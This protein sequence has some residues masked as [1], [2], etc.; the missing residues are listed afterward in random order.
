[1]SKASTN[2]FSIQRYGIRS[3]NLTT[4]FEATL[5]TDTDTDTDTDGDLILKVVLMLLKLGQ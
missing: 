4:V 3:L 1:M 5:D 2:T